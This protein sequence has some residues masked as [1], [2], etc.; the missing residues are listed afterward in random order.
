VEAVVR[1]GLPVPCGRRGA[2]VTRC[3][4]VTGSECTGKT[5]L[6]RALAA[7]LH[8][9]WLPEA[10]RAYA[11]ERRDEGRALTSE[12]VE[13]IARRDIAA[14]DAALRSAPADLVLDT[15]LLSTVAYARHYYG[16]CPAWI[17]A[18]AR[19]RLGALYLLCAPDLPW[20][21]D[22]VRDRPAARESMHAHFRS[23]LREFGAAVTEVGGIGPAREQ[24]AMAAVDAA[25]AQ[26]VEE[27]SHRA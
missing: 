17:E 5:T 3:I 4:V 23:V 27:T 11:E 7:R 13:P 19:A 26:A 14:A 8:A 12:D 9:P 2:G 15:D 18:E 24:A 25:L 22:G 1:G 20:L 6:A 21:A 10:S 16:A